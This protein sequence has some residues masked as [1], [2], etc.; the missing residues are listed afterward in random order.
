MVFSARLDG[1]RYPNFHHP[2]R[3]DHMYEEEDDEDEDQPP[4]TRFLDQ[5]LHSVSPKHKYYGQCLLVTIVCWSIKVARD[6]RTIA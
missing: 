1:P 5:L 6:A 2:F 4:I 3:H